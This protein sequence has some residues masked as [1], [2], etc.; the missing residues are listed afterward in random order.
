MHV[1]C[2]S[3]IPHVFLHRILQEHA[4]VINTIIT[5]ILGVFQELQES[6]NFAIFNIHIHM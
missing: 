2:R 6:A 3:T 1:H 5:E 4:T